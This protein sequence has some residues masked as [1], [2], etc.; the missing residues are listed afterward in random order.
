VKGVQRGGELPDCVQL[1]GKLLVLFTLGLGIGAKHGL[2]TAPLS[3]LM[4]TSL[5]V[6][7]LIWQEFFLFHPNKS[8]YGLQDTIYLFMNNSCQFTFFLELEPRFAISWDA[9]VRATKT[10]SVNSADRDI[11]EKS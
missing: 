10:C 3:G 4:P 1:W 5:S 6:G 9:L 8:C 2:S 7:S 11:L